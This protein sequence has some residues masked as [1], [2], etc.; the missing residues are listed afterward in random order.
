MLVWSP[1]GAISDEVRPSPAFDP[2]TRGYHFPNAFNNVEI[3]L[4]RINLPNTLG[5]I[6]PIN[7]G[8]VNIGVGTYGLCGGMAAGAADHYFSRTATPTTQTTPQSGPLHRY[9]RQNQLDTLFKKP[10]DGI[11]QVLWWIILPE[12]D[13][14]DPVFRRLI[15][16]GVNHRTQN[17]ADNIRGDI[18]ANRVR[19]LIIIKKHLSFRDCVRNLSRCGTRLKELFVGNH[20]ALAV[21][22]FRADADR[23]R[24]KV[25]AGWD[26]NYQGD[27]DAPRG[28][29]GLLPASTLTAGLT[30]PEYAGAPRS[31]LEAYDGITYLYSRSDRQYSDR[32]GTKPV[33]GPRPV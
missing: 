8:T 26:P 5:P 19:P 31:D 3:R 11:A 12:G 29:D 10:S 25:I 27:P 32:R 1:T 20:Q 9:I 22:W 7:F 18:R 6:P 4:G 28:Q 14:R 24:Q 23:D 16:R 15:T 2:A 21:G 13:V 33:S 17:S 30:N